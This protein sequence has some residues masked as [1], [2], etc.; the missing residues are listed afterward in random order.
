MHLSQHHRLGGVSGPTAHN[1]LNWISEVNR[2]L[3]WLGFAGLVAGQSRTIRLPIEGELTK[4]GKRPTQVVRRSAGN[5]PH[6]VV[7]RFPHG[8]RQLVGAAESYYREPLPPEWGLP[9]FPDP[10]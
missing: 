2:L 6:R 8:V 10:L 4:R 5:L 9:T 7:A 1:D 3:P